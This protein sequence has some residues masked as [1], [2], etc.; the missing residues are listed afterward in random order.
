MPQCMKDNIADGLREINS[1]TNIQ[2]S[3]N[4]YIAYAYGTKDRLASKE[5]YYNECKAYEYELSLGLPI[6]DSYKRTMQ[7]SYWYYKFIYDNYENIKKT[8]R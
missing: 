6:S 4:D 2:M 7:E 8:K 1:D 3:L 5:Y